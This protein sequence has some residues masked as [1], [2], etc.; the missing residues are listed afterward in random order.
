MKEL[1]IIIYRFLNTLNILYISLVK[2]NVNLNPVLFLNGAIAGSSA[3]P[4]VKV[5]RLRSLFKISRFNPNIFYCLSNCIYSYNYVVIKYVKSKIPIIYNQNGIFYKAWFKGD[6]VSKNK[7]MEFYLRNSDYVFYQSQFCKRCC[8]ETI[9]KRTTN[10]KILY[11]AV[12]TDIFIPG[13]KLKTSYISILKIGTY[14]K[15]NIWRLLDTIETIHNVNKHRIYKYK[16]S[17]VGSVDEYSKN[18]A[19]LLISKYKMKRDIFFL[20]KINQNKLVEIMQKHMIFLTTK[21]HDPCSNAIIEAMACGLPV[22]FHNSGGNIELVDKAGWGFG[23]KQKSIKE[24]VINKNELLS[25]LKKIT[26]KEISYKSK[27]AR[28]RAE[29]YFNISKWEKEHIEI[30]KYF[31]EKYKKPEL[32]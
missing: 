9:Y 30:F 20:G 12:D 2:K 15:E 28:Y 26:K 1:I 10:Y 24:I 22:I 3:G 19:M 5:T 16:L 29:K 7:K 32:K 25:K 4:K 8:D 17:I 31:A 21:I 11:N 14:T 27:H 13:K 6:V 23:K 18:R